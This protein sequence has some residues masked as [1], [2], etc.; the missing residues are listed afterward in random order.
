MIEAIL[1]DNRNFDTLAP[2]L[3][4][5]IREKQFIGFDIETFDEPHEGINRF[6]KGKDTRAFDARRTTVTGFSLYPQNSGERAFYVNLNHADVENRVPWEKA[7]TLLDAK[8]DES[9]WVSHNAPFELTMMSNSLSYNLGNVVCTLQMAVSTYGPD[10]YDTTTY[11]F[12]QLGEIKTLFPK[13]AKLFFDKDPYDRNLTTE[14]GEVF[15]QVLGKQS[16]AAHSYNG[17]VNSISY[18]YGLK[19]AV[20]S[21]FGHEMASFEETVGKGRNMGDLTGEEVV[22]Y[23][24]DDAYWCVRLFEQLM[25]V[26]VS[27]DPKLARTFFDQENPMV[28]VFSDI[29]KNG[30]RVNTEAVRE[31]QRLE[32]AEYAK[33]LR[34]LKK[35]IKATGGYPTKHNEKMLEV[36]S[37]YEK[38]PNGYRTKIWSWACTPEKDKDF[39]EV[40]LVGGAVSE[41]WRHELGLPKSVGVNLS[42]YMATRSIMYDLLNQKLIISK[43]KVQSDGEARGKVLDRGTL[44][45]NGRCII[46]L[47]SEIGGIEQRMKLYLNPYLLLIDPETNRMYPQVS[48][49]LATRRMAMSNPNGMQLAKRGASTYVRGFYEADQDDHIIISADWSQVELV[50]V[51]EL[52][53]DPEFKRAYGQTPYLDLHLGAAADALRVAIPEITEELMSNLHKMSV[54]EIN[55]INPLILINPEGERMDPAKAKKFWRTEVGKGSNFNY[56]YSGALSTVGD[57]LGWT[58]DQMWEATENYRRRFA[59]AEEWRVN[60]IDQCKMRGFVT[61][62]DGHRRERFEAT[63]DWA[64]QTQAMFDAHGLQGLSNFGKMMVRSIQ[65]RAGNQAVNAMIQGTSATLAK[66]SILRGIK[67]IKNEGYDARFMMPIHDELVW[68][69][70]R[71]QAIPF[72][73][74]LKKVMVNHPDI[75][76]D[77]VLHC[78]VSVGNTFEPYDAKKAPYGQIELDETPDLS[79]LPEEVWGGACNDNEIAQVLEYLNDAA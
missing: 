18:G 59:V 51:G 46:H 30:F 55:G 12:A 26:M 64:M 56:W 13:I 63:F 22:A 29:W 11:S 34:E 60:T 23:G 24:A 9:Y 66:R 49:K 75:V 67:M 78:T 2:A 6:R 76:S 27:K 35:L 57:R 52:S 47:L 21:F 33:T 58:S 62:P 37:W 36:E 42:Y 41:A 15:A 69:V 7:R 72:I 38:N 5:L 61:L 1:I 4:D 70:N 20:R 43:G 71:S 16:K 39:D 3:I 10:N 17:F 53:G 28:H 44:D 25:T 31:Y 40:S 8:D 68:S 14:Q 50:L 45:D 73:H 74:D 54:E 65:S 32:R 19:K 77:L 48:S 79:F